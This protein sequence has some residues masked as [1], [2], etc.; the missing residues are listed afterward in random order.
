MPPKARETAAAARKTA[1]AVEWSAADV[2]VLIGKLR[3]LPNPLA[4]KTILRTVERDPTFPRPSFYRHPSSDRR[5]DAGGKGR[6]PIWMSDRTPEFE[7]WERDRKPA[8]T[9]DWTTA[10]VGEFLG[11]FRLRG[12]PAA[13]GHI[14]IRRLVETDPTF[15]QPSYYIHSRSGTRVEEG[16]R[17]RA[18]MWEPGREAEFEE[19]A[20]NRPRGGGHG[21]VWPKP[22]QLDD[23]YIPC[24]ECKHPI[25]RH[26]RTGCH[27]V[28]GSCPC[29]VKS[30]TVPKVKGARLAA[31]LPER[32]DTETSTI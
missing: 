11:Q 22:A 29:T 17:G 20:T 30:W 6:S 12:E 21:R 8:P 28:K 25:E 2:G 26:N 1:P 10:D 15:P 32:Y 31:G 24:V 27:P 23:G 13:L 19:W 5:L 3:S 4:A 16:G 14:H 7:A 18:P 9:G